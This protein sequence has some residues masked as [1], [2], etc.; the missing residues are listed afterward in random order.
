[1]CCFFSR[2][3]GVSL[4]SCS[5]STYGLTDGGRAGM[6]YVYLTS[7]IGFFAAVISMAEI[8]S[9]YVPPPAGHPVRS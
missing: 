6:L 2:T 8:A 1:M 4:T 9:M 3:R 7:F 5:T